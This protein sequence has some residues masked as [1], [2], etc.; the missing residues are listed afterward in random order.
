MDKE[1]L[2]ALTASIQQLEQEGKVS[3]TFRRLDPERQ[4]AILEAAFSE[5]AEKSPAHMNIKNVAARAGVSIGSLYQYFKDRDQLLGFAIEIC[6]R[7]MKDLFR[8]TKAYFDG[9]P[10]REALTA[11]LSF[12]VEW[13]RTQGGFVK[14]FGRAA[15]SGDASLTESLV[16]P[17]ADMMRELMEGIFAAAAERGEIRADVDG[18]AAARAVNALVIAV[19]DSSLMPHLNGYFQVTGASMP[20]TRIA[21]AVVDLIMRGI[22]ARNG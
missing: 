18:A 2:Q 21:D 17:I 7:T 1:T 16:T 10:L 8:Q 19:G 9:M 3:R 14:F 22:G 6:V 13:S 20:Y 15:Y 12:G 5:A 4:W 11:Y